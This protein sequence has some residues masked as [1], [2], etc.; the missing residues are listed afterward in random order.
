MEAFT[1]HKGLVAPLDREN[2]DT[3][4]IMPK[5]FLKSIKR[6]GFGPNLFD[7]LR[8][9]DVGEPGMDN[10][11]RPL[12]P[13]F[14]LN[15]PRYQ[16][17]SVLLT[18][19]NFGCGSSREH[20]PWALL[21]FGF[22]AI[23]APSYADIFF[24]NCFKNGLL[25]IVQPEEVVSEL[26]REMEATP[27]YEL[28]VDLDAQTITKPNGDVLKFDVEPFRKHCLLNGLDD[29][30]TTLQKADKIRA[31]EA[32]RLARFPWLEGLPG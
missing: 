27:G 28:T 29:I 31:F 14:S 9:L 20:A 7:T 32:D 5:Q 18:R 13:D 19:K 4:L 3:D 24:N 25:P 16:G 22:R 23:I 2:V 8:Y 10:S 21:Q 15:Q 12:N 11:K 30:A 1:T 26:F 17:A 6:T